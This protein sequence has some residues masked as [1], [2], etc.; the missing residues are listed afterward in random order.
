MLSG[1]AALEWALVFQT[2]SGARRTF[3]PKAVGQL[4]LFCSYVTFRV[5][6]HSYPS[7]GRALLP[8]RRRTRSAEIAGGLFFVHPD[9]SY[10][11]LAAAS[12]Q[13]KI[14]AGGFPEEAFSKK[15]RV[16][17]L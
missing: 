1:D 11:P 4:P 2:A 12:H 7:G 17:Y 3:F 6:H 5:G 16:S 15:S 8:A 14:G 9:C 13:S 10:A